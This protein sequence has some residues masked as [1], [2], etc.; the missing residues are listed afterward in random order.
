MDPDTFNKIRLG[1]DYEKVMKN[2]HNFLDIKE[3]YGFLV[4]DLDY[5]AALIKGEE[6]VKAIDPN[7]GRK[8]TATVVNSPQALLTGDGAVQSSLCPCC[9]R[10]EN[11]FRRWSSSGSPVSTAT[12]RMAG[13]IPGFQR[14][15]QFL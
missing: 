7:E 14:S 2:I 15:Q 10:S 12:P 11:T 13:R 1:A 6:A 4:G 8:L 3:K 9:H 5:N